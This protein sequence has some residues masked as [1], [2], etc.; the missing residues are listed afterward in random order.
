MKK[1]KNNHF[2]EIEIFEC[3]CKAVAVLFFFFKIL[4]YNWRV[5]TIVLVFAIHQH[6]SASDTYMSI[7]SFISL[8]PAA[9]Q[10]C[11]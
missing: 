1:K 7:L 11:F 4:I 9:L 10:H 5:V 6:E 8:P 3:V 2:P